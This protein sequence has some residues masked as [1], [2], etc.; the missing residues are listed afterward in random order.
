MDFYILNYPYIPEI[1]PTWLWWVIILMCSWIHLARILLSIFS[2]MFIRETGPKFSF[3][4]WSVYGLCISIIV[5]AYNELGSVPS[6]SIFWNSLKSIGIKYSL[7]VWEN[8]ALN[9]SGSGLFLVERLLRT[10]SI[11]LGLWGCL[12]GLSDAVLTL[13]PCMFLENCPFHPDFSI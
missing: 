4:I 1:K 5:A 3:F 10:A 9:T 11:S 8:S 12:D 2:S 13:A 6:V 7:N